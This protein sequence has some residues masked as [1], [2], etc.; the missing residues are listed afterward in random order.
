MDVNKKVLTFLYEWYGRLF[1][2]LLF[3]FILRWFF[4]KRGWKYN[5]AGW[6]ISQAG[7]VYHPY[8]YEKYVGMAE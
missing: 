8:V 6:M 7:Y 5:F 3:T 2:S 4:E 1:C